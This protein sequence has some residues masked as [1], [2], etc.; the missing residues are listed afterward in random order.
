MKLLDEVRHAIRVRHYSMDTDQSYVRWV[1]QY[2]K[3]GPGVCLAPVADHAAPLMFIATSRARSLSRAE[4]PN[5]RLS[6]RVSSLRPRSWVRCSV[7][8]L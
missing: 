3:G 6:L 1:E 4:V 7:T 2:V 5:K 8:A